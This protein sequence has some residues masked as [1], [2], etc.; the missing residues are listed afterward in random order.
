M[1]FDNETMFCEHE[2]CKARRAVTVASTETS[3]AQFSCP[4]IEMVQKS[5]GLCDT[6]EMT[7]KMVSEY[8]CDDTT[9]KKLLSLL[10]NLNE[11][12]AVVLAGDGCY[13]VYGPPSSA[14][15]M[16]Y[17]HLFVNSNTY[18]CT[19]KNCKVISGA[20]KQQKIS[21]MCIHQHV[22]LC[23]LRL[24]NKV[25]I[26]TTSTSV[27]EPHATHTSDGHISTIKANLD[28]CIPAVISPELLNRTR[29]TDAATLLNMKEVKNNSLLNNF[30]FFSL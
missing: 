17:T 20:G 1:V 25:T 23:S 6:K 9:R 12:P 26:P 7:S 21:K 22:L 24:A 30:L 18:K 13:I 28:K 27:H 10:P 29:Q 4:H 11:M 2:K 14:S 15:T 3:V 19:S 8:P 5:E 16:G